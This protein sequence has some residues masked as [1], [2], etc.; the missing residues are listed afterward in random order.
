[1][2]FAVPHGEGAAVD[3]F[4]N[5]ASRGERHGVAEECETRR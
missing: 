4:F 5:P 1:M 2:E 3:A